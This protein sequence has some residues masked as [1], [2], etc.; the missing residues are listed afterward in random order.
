MRKKRQVP[1]VTCPESV[2]RGGP[3]KDEGQGDPRPSET[4]ETHARHAEDQ[5]HN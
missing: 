4:R 5:R 2:V 3:L 1:Q